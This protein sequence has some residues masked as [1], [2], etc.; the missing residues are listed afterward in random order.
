MYS[1]AGIAIAHCFIQYNKTIGSAHAAQDTRPLIWQGLYFP[2]HGA[3][4][5]ILKQNSALELCAAGVLFNAFRAYHIEE[6]HRP[7]SLAR[8]SLQSRL[9]KL[10]KRHHGGYRV[11]WQAKIMSRL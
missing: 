11:T 7:V 6:W 8:Y 2:S 5:H 9:Y 10:V 1:C 3:I 4:V